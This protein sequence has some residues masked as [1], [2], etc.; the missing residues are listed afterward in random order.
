[1]APRSAALRRGVLVRRR[2]PLSR[3]QQMAMFAKQNALAVR[4]QKLV[5]GV[6]AQAVQR[7]P[8]LTAHREDLAQAGMIGLIQHA[9]RYNPQK[10]AFSTLGVVR[11]KKHVL[12]EAKKHLATVTVGERKISSLIR[13]GTLPRN[14]SLTSKR[15]T[16][17]L[18]SKAKEQGG[19]EAS[20]AKI[21]VQRLLRALS[22]KER[23]VV[24][25]RFLE[26]HPVK[27]VAKRLRLTPA[28]VKKIQLGAMQK[29]RAQVKEAA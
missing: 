28:R 12:R 17:H 19:L 11:I 16:T 26:D 24:Q 3:R 4:H 10:G 29:L 6:V 1:M 18:M 20:A 21:D 9:R 22:V 8:H 7:Y 14:V 25:L 5:H 27:L 15:A 23:Q 2:A 13:T